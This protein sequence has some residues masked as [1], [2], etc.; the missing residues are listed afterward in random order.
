MQHYAVMPAEEE[1]LH[2]VNPSQVLGHTIGKNL[3]KQ[4]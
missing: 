4:S 3:Q 2:N 1:E